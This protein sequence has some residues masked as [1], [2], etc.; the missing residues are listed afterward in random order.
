MNKL[1]KCIER[2]LQ[3][4]TVIM[5]ILSVVEGIRTY[6]YKKELK[7]KADDYLNDEL[8]MEGNIRGSV[9]VFSPT[10]KEKEE[11]V[12]KLLAITGIGC[13]GIIIL[14]LINRDI[15]R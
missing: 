1:L 11:K 12:L 5:G 9:A 2:I 15:N 10:L 6:L 3:V 4:A 14:N 7:T 8:E 13:L